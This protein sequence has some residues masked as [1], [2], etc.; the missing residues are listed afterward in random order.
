MSVRG[1]DGGIP[2]I[3]VPNP[4]Q[5]CTS[6]IMLREQVGVTE[7]LECGWDQGKRVGET[8][9]I[10]IQGPVVD[11]GSQTH[12]LLSNKKEAGPSRG[13]RWMDGRTPV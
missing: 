1:D 6:W 5:V 11:T 9:S 12:I 4:Y 8:F 10:P 7:L 13:G 2:F 3:S